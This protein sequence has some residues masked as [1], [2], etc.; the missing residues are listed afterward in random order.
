MWGR[1]FAHIATST[2]WTFP[3]IRRLT[4]FDVEDLNRYW[5]KYPPVHQAFAAFIGIGREDPGVEKVKDAAGMAGLA[6]AF[7]L[8]VRHGTQK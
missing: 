1:L 6:S 2:G 5:A 7:G 4:L 8:E 3:V